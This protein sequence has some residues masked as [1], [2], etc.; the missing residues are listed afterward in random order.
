[1]SA[2]SENISILSEADFQAGLT[3]IAQ[4]SLELAR[5]VLGRELRI[6]TVCFFTHSPEE[7]DFVRAKVAQAGPESKFSHGATLYVDVDLQLQRQNITLLGVRSPDDTRTEA[8]YADYPVNNYQEV[9]AE[10]QGS[11]YAHEIVSGQGIPLI[12]LR[13][14]DFNVRGY[15]AAESVT[16]NG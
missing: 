2:A 15:I 3:R 10:L 8:G 1:M 13:H 9:L 12:E 4:S 7:Y 14:P 16:K 11:A 6:D 5:T